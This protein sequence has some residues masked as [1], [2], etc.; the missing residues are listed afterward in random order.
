MQTRQTRSYKMVLL[1]VLQLVGHNNEC[2]QQ[3]FRRVQ[4]NYCIYIGGVAYSQF[5]AFTYRSTSTTWMYSF[6]AHV[7]IPQAFA[8]TCILSRADSF[9]QLPRS[10]K[11]SWVCREKVAAD[12]MESNAYTHT[13]SYTHTHAHK[14]DDNDILSA[15]TVRTTNVTTLHKCSHMHSTTW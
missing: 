15:S 2:L 9:S 4:F 13:L 5:D 11:V 6:K 7:G 14:E 3:P 10:Y 12:K 8:A 1:H